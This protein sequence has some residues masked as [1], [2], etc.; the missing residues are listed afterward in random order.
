M[1]QLIHRVK[2]VITTLLIQGPGYSANFEVAT[3]IAN[4]QTSELNS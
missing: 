4:E 1:I 3:F 2:L